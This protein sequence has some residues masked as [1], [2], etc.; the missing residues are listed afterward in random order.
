MLP[1]RAGYVGNKFTAEYSMNDE[2]IFKMSFTA[3][4]IIRAEEVAKDI[5]RSYLAG[6]Y[7]W[8]KVLEGDI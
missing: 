2:V 7:R 4:D 1:K 5:G 8:I 6:R 3:S